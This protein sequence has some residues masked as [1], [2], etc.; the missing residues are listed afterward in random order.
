M[1]LGTVEPCFA[2]DCLPPERNYESRDAL[3]KSINAWAA[4]KG[5]AFT[6]GKS[7]KSTSGR[8]KVTYACDRSCHPPSTSR[9]R[10][11]NTTTRG[12]S[13]P[14]SVLAKESLDKSTWSLQYRPDKR[15]SL[16]NHA[17]SQHP[18]A[19]PVHRTL[20]E[21]VKSKVASLSNAGI[22]PKDIRTYIRQDGNSLATQQDIYNRMAATRRDSCEGQST[23][24]A[25]ASQLDKEGF[26]SRMQVIPDGRVTS[27]LFAHPDSLA[28]LQAYPDIL[29]LDCTYK[30]NKYGMPLLDMIGVDACQRSF[31][32]AFAFLSGETEDDY[33]WALDQLKSLYE[34]CTARLPSVILTDRCI[35]CMNAVS[36]CFPSSFSLLCIWH[37]N[38]A[39]LRHCLPAFTA[40]TSCTTSAAS[41]TGPWEE[42]YQS[43]HSII[44]SPDEDTFD[45]R[46]LDFE[47]KYLPDYL[48]EVGY[49]KTYWLDP[50]KE[51]LVKAW[52]DQH[53]HF[54]NV[55]TSRVEGIH[56]LLKSYLKKSTL[57]LFEAWRAMKHALLNQLSELR[58]NQAKQQVR[59]PIELSGPLYSTV[60]GWVSHE[61]LRKIE[62]Q[63]KLLAR[64]DPP[65]SPSCN[66][67]FSQVQGLPCLHT[68]KTLEEQNRVLL[69][70]HFHSHWHLRRDGTPQL[71]LEPR[72]RIDPVNRTS[73]PKQ[74]TRR[75]PSQFEAVEA[76]AAEASSTRAL[77]RCSRCHALGHTRSAKACP[78]RYTDILSATTSEPASQPTTALDSI[79]VVTSAQPPTSPIRTSP[80]RTSPIRTSP[81]LPD[82]SPCSPPR[83][84]SPQA[85]YQR[86]IAARSA[87]YKSQ[88]RASI[89]TNQQYRKAMGL[90]SRYGKKSYE[91]C[92]DYKQMTKHCRTSTGSREWTKEE[93][94]A[95]LDWSEAEDKRI[96]AQVAREMEGNLG[97]QRQGMGEVWR[98]VDRDIEE[99]EAL[100]EGNR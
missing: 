61:A 32:I 18:S 90:P 84:D 88:P 29:F 14:F 15:F 43:W 57:D 41:E 52:V 1:S 48:E 76:E 33:S 10:Q 63:R 3:F 45:E 24:H 51:K 38:K 49:I 6:T 25:L 55:A 73:G 30:T 56:A 83:Y 50:Y 82:P 79:E 75:E 9:E 26:W 91:W 54:G 5:Y 31:C 35:A 4:T 34:N 74:S 8:W 92:L 20:S 2:E 69:L 44:G 71:L 97:R 28:Y 80:I 22:A 17:P 47:R 40:S 86:Y 64:K 42:F 68:L 81:P 46:V 11:R 78:L 16:H 67:S 39:V 27:V 89:K 87:W 77:S 98:M 60:R 94:M 7:T 53:T 62:E 36:T 72:Q 23:I 96:E 58:S 12:T 19:H 100:Y 99:Q 85:I 59:I 21:E 65:P 13:C 93:M 70:E 95:Y 37:A 66:G